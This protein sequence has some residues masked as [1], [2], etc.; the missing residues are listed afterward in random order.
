MSLGFRG[1]AG[2]SVVVEWWCALLIKWY[3][4]CIDGTL[5]GVFEDGD[6]GRA[7]VRWD[8]GERCGSITLVIG[9]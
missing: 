7:G 3:C 1:G 9:S 6:E 2:G 8:G 4:L 5:A